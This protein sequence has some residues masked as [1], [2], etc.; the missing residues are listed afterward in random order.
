MFPQYSGATTGA[1]HDRVMGELARWRRL[2][3]L[4]FIS[5]YHDRPA[6]IEALRASVV[7]HWAAERKTRHLV[8]SFHGIPR[9]YVQAG[10]PYERECQRTAR[11]L[12]DA[13]ELRDDEWTMS[14]QSRFGAAEWLKP[15]TIDLMGELARPRHR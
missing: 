14:F 13:L 9:R 7:A 4:R 2:P 11:L 8:I 12:A 15:Y 6:Y 1:V 3:E 10:D 5:G